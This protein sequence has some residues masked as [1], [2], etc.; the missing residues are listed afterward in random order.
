M[1]FLLFYVA[2]NGCSVDK[3]SPPAPFVETATIAEITTPNQGAQAVSAVLQS[4]ELVVT[5]TNMFKD[6]GLIAKVQMVT[7]PSITDLSSASTTT[8]TGACGDYGTY[9][10]TSNYGGS[11]GI[12]EVSCTFSLCRQNGF[13]YDGKFTAKG[14]PDNFQGNLTGLKILNFQNSYKTLIGSLEGVSLIFTMQGTGDA[15]NASYTFI[16]NGRM[17]AFDYYSLG[18]HDMAFTKLVTNYIVVTD[19]ATNVQTSQMNVNGNYFVNKAG[20]KVTLTYAN[21][22][23]DKQKQLTAN[24]EDVSTNGRVVVNYSPNSYLE[25]AFDV[26]TTTPV[27]TIL[28]PFPPKT[29][30]GTILV[31]NAATAQYGLSDSLDISVAGST[32]NFAKEF[33]LMKQNDFY[34]MEQQLPIVKG[35]SGTADGAIMS[36]SALSTAPTSTG[37]SCYTDVHVSYYTTTAPTTSDSTLWVVDWKTSTSTCKLTSAIP[38]QQGTSSTGVS[39]DPCDVGLDINGAATDITSGGVEHFLAAALPMGYYVLSI[40]N[41]SCS[42]DVHNEAS[43]I[44]GD[45]LFG[46]YTC[47]YGSSD[48]DGSTPN[49][50]CRLADVRVKA[51]GTIDVI[52]PNNALNPWH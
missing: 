24:T 23:V 35:P 26:V 2:L 18:Q 14:K 11:N 41:Y 31:N 45:Y 40:N 39:T 46:T 44:I 37:L 20:K 48:G 49:A 16:A 21:F 43:L 51:D 13:Q 5:S 1:A 7:S 10:F 3:L 15:S 6:L 47:S 12:Y 9:D 28:V 29:N 17:K 27:R 8:G 50:W 33:I 25:G 38:F 42:T 34:A 4:K 30:Q 36:I 52:S 22:T 32:I 19:N